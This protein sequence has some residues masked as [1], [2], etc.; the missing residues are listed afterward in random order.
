MYGQGPEAGW[1]PDPEGARLRWWDGTAW[2]S[3]VHVGESAP[4]PATATE[5]ASTGAGRPPAP[6]LA[7]GAVLVIAVAVAAFLLLRSSDE[8]S[9]TSSPS[10]TA[11][12]TRVESKPAGHAAVARAAFDAFAKERVHSAQVAIETYATEHGGSYSGATPAILQRIEPSLPTGLGVVGAGSNSYALTMRS[13]SGEVFSIVRRP[14]GKV[15]FTC[16]PPG[17]GGC[18]P[19]GTW[20]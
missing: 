10:S 16:A 13:E 4:S 9:S 15:V 11:A 20:E 5:Q 3:H 18:P 17:R 2:T 19:S 6:T 12:P 7:L 8:G 1:Y 14:S